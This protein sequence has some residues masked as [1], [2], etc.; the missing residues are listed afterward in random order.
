M[1]Y[2]YVDRNCHNNNI[3]H[4][5]HMPMILLFINHNIRNYYNYYSS[6]IVPI[7]IYMY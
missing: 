7:Y 6:I 1:Q 5:K 2:A 3:I 4:I